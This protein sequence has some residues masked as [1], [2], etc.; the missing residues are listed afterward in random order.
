MAINVSLERTF[1]GFGV[2]SLQ[3]IQRATGIAV[4]SGT[5]YYVPGTSSNSVAGL[6]VPTVTVGRVRVKVYNGSGTSPTLTKLQIMGFDG[7]NSVV[8]ADWNFGTAVT[9]SSTS[10]AD[11]M[12]DFICDTAPSTTSG[13]AVGFLIGSASAVT[14]NGGI[15]CIKVIP[16]LGGTGPACTMDVEIFGLI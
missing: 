10:W 5:T 12:T 9:L 14:G 7:T 16:T 11:L 13:G 6:L 8:I 1:P 15:Q 3:S 4:S 2:S